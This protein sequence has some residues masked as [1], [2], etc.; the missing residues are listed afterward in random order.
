MTKHSKATIQPEEIRDVC[1]REYG[2]KNNPGQSLINI[3]LLFRD[4]KW[5][6]ANFAAHRE[7]ISRG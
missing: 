6:R 3:E 7:Q 1:A 4:Q 2:K 5:I